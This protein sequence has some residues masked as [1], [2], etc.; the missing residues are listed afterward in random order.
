MKEG[1][2]RP[3]VISGI[4]NSRTASCENRLGVSSCSIHL[5]FEAY[6]SP[7]IITREEL[8]PDSHT[9]N[10]GLFTLSAR[11]PSDNFLLTVQTGCSRTLP[12]L[13]CDHTGGLF[14]RIMFA[15]FRSIIHQTSRLR[16][17]VIAPQATFSSTAAHWN[18]DAA[19]RNA[20]DSEHLLKILLEE[21]EKQESRPVAQAAGSSRYVPYDRATY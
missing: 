7:A 13:T 1:S 10:A 8:S 12:R 16:P 18:N 17:A 19:A 14:I 21:G 6:C 3:T 4:R 20:K 15:S 9:S 11:H 5:L 2:Q